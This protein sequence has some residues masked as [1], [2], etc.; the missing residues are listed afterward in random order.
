M[1]LH[2]TPVPSITETPVKTSPPGFPED[3]SA[4]TIHRVS[5]WRQTAPNEDDS[6][7]TTEESEWDE[8][9]DMN[10]LRRDKMSSWMDRYWGEEEN[11]EEQN[12]SEDDRELESD[13]DSSQI[14]EN[15]KVTDQTEAEESKTDY[16]TEKR[17]VFGG[18]GEYDRCLLEESESWDGEIRS[19]VDDEEVESD[20]ESLRELGSDWAQEWEPFLQLQ[21]LYRPEEAELQ[22]E[23]SYSESE[24]ESVMLS[25]EWLLFVVYINI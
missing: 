3:L 21:T 1:N 15:V 13:E 17:V 5:T 8:D 24:E 19:V 16:F 20:L 14:N 7:S 10:R 9:A 4:P 2:E 22:S 12:F 6:D 23:D 18:C 11:N 25:G